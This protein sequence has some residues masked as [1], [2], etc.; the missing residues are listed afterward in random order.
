ML[1]FT[2]V[3]ERLL[4]LYTGPQIGD[5]ILSMRLPCEASHCDHDFIDDIR[6]ASPFLLP[7]RRTCHRTL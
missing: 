4:Y 3:S 2:S 5:V 6:K 1:P 7:P